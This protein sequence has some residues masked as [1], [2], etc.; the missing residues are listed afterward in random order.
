VLAHELERLLVFSRRRI[1]HPEQ[2]VWFE[3][4]S[5]ARGFERREAMVHVVQ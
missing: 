4:L 2:P 5:E 1:F 3:R